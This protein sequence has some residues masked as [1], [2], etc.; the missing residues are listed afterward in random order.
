MNTTRRTLI[1][2]ALAAPALAACATG[3]V[4]TGPVSGGNSTVALGR[5]WSDITALMYARRPRNLKVL[6][7]D[8]PLLNRLYVATLEPGDSLLRP[9]D[10][11]TPRPTFRDDM[12]DTEVVEFVIDCVAQEYQGP[13]SAA[14]RPQTFG[15]HPGVRFDF[16]ANTTD[17]LNMSG[18]ALA[19]RVGNR[20]HL[21]LF[22]APTEHYYGAF[23]QEV[24]ALFA[25]ATLTS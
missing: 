20:L 10:R 17:G 16:T 14:L 3:G 15:G 5:E 8:G 9:R 13:E 1:L 23:L 24:D 19:A 21:L 7:I 25:N 11:D 2:G 12:S 6:S 4:V 18:T 22:L